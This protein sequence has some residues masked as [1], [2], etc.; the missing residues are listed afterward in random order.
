M[1]TKMKI[2]LLLLTLTL[3]TACGNVAPPT[4]EQVKIVADL[5]EKKGLLV[6]VFY[7]GIYTEVKC[8]QM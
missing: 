6:N 8:I 2:C 7:N 4:N 5:C 1:A 3:L